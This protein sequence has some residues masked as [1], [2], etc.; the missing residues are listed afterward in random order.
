MV[1]EIAEE[2]YSKFYIGNLSKQFD[3]FYELVITF[4]LFKMSMRAS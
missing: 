3:N 4:T 1:A 2:W